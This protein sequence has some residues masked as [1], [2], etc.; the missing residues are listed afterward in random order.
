MTWGSDDD[1][2]TKLQ[3]QPEAGSWE[4]PGWKLAIVPLK[5]R[6]SVYAISD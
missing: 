4:D 2:N 6:W 1:L 3:A 5:D